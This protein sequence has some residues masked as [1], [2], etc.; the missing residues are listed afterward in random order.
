MPHIVVVC[1]VVC[2]V[3]LVRIRERAGIKIEV[4][5]ERDGALG[6]VSVSV[7]Y[8]SKKKVTLL[9]AHDDNAQNHETAAAQTI[10]TLCIVKN[11]NVVSQTLCA[12]R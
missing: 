2:C 3:G 6:L 10:Y 11:E 8:N 7:G 12:G 9:G 4:V 5:G 1:C